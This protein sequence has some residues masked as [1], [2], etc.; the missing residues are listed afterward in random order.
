M[1]GFRLKIQAGGPAFLHF[2]AFFPVVGSVE[3]SN[4]FIDLYK[5]FPLF[6]YGALRPTQTEDLLLSCS[7]VHFIPF[8]YLCPESFYLPF[9]LYYTPPRR[10]VN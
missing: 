5:F 2:P 10:P 6:H 9:S 3:V 1:R 8:P 4:S 7:P